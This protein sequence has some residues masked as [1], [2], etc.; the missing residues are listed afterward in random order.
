[1]PDPRVSSALIDPAEAAFAATAV[2]ERL[3]KLVG[4]AAGVKQGSDIEF[5]HR[6]RVASRRLRTALRV[7]GDC[8]PHRPLKAWQQQVRRIT[9]SLSQA[10]DLDVQ[11]EFI[12][13]FD[14]PR[15]KARFRPGIERLELRFKQQRAALQSKVVKRVEK[16]EASRVVESM[17]DRLGPLARG[18]DMTPS[19]SI[20]IVSQAEQSGNPVPTSKALLRRARREIAS[21][22]EELLGFRGYV[23][24][25]EC[26][27]ELH[28]MRIATKHLRYSL[29]LF[30]PLF[31]DRLD[32][33]IAKARDVQTLLGELHDADVWLELLPEFAR[34][35]RQRAIEYSGSDRA[36]PRLVSGL[37]YLKLR[38]TALRRKHYREFA[39]T[40]HQ[41]EDDRVWV[42]L[43]EVVQ[44]DGSGGHGF[45]GPGSGQHPRIPEPPNPCS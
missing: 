13:R 24:R 8:L 29:E 45:K 19:S 7:F 38:V 17:E 20:G 34:I 41:A 15:L 25:P 5:V 44:D 4:E 33:F 27:V 32:P 22:L 42:L 14:T 6:M 3:K 18:G 31:G 16:F 28:Q 21:H 39:R 40:W 43:A 23:D 11:I 1:M 2:L 36:F 35:E 30:R 10:R 12:D 9:R 26:A 37:D